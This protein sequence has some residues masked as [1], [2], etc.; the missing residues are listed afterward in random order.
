MDG[1]LACQ[2]MI[3]EPA[4]R[5]KEGHF[6]NQEQIFDRKQYVDQVRQSFSENPQG[7]NGVQNKMKQSLYEDEQTEEKVPGGFFKIRLLISFLLFIGFIFLWQTGWSYQGINSETIQK[8]IETSIQLPESFPE[9][10]DVVSKIKI[11]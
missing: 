1:M 8:K 7:K 11:E 6:M 5:K 4:K 2:Y 10:S 9:L 3:L